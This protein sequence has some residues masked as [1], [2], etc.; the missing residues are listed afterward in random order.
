M[1]REDIA[2]QA[3]Q[4]AVQNDS[5]TNYEAI[6]EGFIE[7]GIAAEDI[8]PRVNVFTFNAWRALNRSVRKGEHGV[9]IST[10]IPCTKK[11]PDTGE[12]ISV[13]KAKTT[14]VFHISQTDE[15]SPTPAVQ[16]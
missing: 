9:K 16:H 1:N 12:E 7:K 5:L 4:N 8:T 3:L 6:Y 14:T 11:D 15:L 2:Q 10:L 13:M